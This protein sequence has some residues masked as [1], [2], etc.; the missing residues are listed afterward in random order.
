M[1]EIKL[2]KLLEIR[3]AIPYPG[4]VRTASTNNQSYKHTIKVIRVYK[5]IDE[6][7]LIYK[8][9]NMNEIDSQRQNNIK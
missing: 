1:P 5:Y 8:R 6:S 3:A 4:V 7:N 9:S 2:S